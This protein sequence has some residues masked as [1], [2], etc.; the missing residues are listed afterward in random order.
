MPPR[1]LKSSELYVQLGRTG[2][3]INILPLLYS[4]SLKGIKPHLLV[5][6]QYLSI[7]EG[8]SYVEP[9]AYH[10]DFADLNGA[11]S[12]VRGKYRTF[13]VTQVYAHGLTY[14]HHTD[15]FLK[16]S[17]NRVG[18]LEDWGR[19]PLI[20]DRRNYI[21]EKELRDRFLSDKPLILVAPRGISSPFHHFK[22][23]FDVLEKEL[24]EDY[25]ILDL[26]GIQA[27]RFFDLL[28]LMDAA[29]ALVTIDTAHMHLAR[30]SK[31]PTIALVTD[32]PTP[33]HTS[34]PL[35]GQI[36]RMKYSEFPSRAMDVVGAIKNIKGLRLIKSGGKVAKA[37]HTGGRRFFHCY[38]DYS[39]RSSE[40]H[41]R[42]IFAMKTWEDE[43]SRASLV[44]WPVTMDRLTRTS[45]SAFG[46][47]RQMP[48][49]RDLVDDCITR[50]QMNQRDVLILTNDDIAC[51]RGICSWLNEVTDYRAAWANRWDFRSLTQTLTTEQ[52]RCGMWCVGTDL[53]AFT[54]HWWTTHRDEF[55]DMVLG[56]EAW[57]WV[58][59]EI[60]RD[61]GGFELHA[62]VY[63]QWHASFWQ[64]GRNRYENLGNHH[65]QLLAKKYL[66]DR[67]KPIRE[68]AA[69]T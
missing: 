53:F 69:V 31:I 35:S 8:V 20:F 19:L 2:D 50:G 39:P 52:V 62:M 40:A 54:P 16:E 49:I 63:H 57:D 32:G 46:D 26:A 38:N 18:R 17:W 5:S 28:G 45:Q 41:S 60:I 47:K 37:E 44:S 9:V 24:G 13:K 12:S 65:N 56:C 55:P 29:A 66:Q 27:N 25:T 23:L 58:L 15:S 1:A 64:S 4:E 51:V 6:H 59:R 14:A 7:L 34:A 43:R 42:H 33:W 68:L 61:S 3:V 30:A 22:M 11:L 36:L 10:G 48:F 21:R 67:G